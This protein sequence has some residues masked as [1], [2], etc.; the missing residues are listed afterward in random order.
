MCVCVGAGREGI[1]A[2]FC[3]FVF[4]RG[5]GAER[6]SEPGLLAAG[7]GFRSGE[8]KV[9]LARGRSRATDAAPVLVPEDPKVRGRARLDPEEGTRRSL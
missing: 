2:R 1:L 7:L 4:P 8:G 3:L 5:F 6:R 9:I